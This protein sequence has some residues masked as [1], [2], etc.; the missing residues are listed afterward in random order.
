V[1]LPQTTLGQISIA[2]WTD[3]PPPK[4]KK[5]KLNNKQA[6]KKKKRHIAKRAGC[7]SSGEWGKGNL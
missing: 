3:G 7:P 4:G 6:V 1:V 5:N 2:S